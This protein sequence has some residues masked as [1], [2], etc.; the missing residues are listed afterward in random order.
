MKKTV[1]SIAVTVIALIGLAMMLTVGASAAE[2]M[3][4]PLESTICVWYD[5]IDK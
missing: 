5:K 3:Q 4:L 1:Y 2:E